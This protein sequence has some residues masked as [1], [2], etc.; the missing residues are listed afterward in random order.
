M[1]WLNQTYTILLPEEA[2]WRPSNIMKIPNTNLAE[3]L[4]IIKP[5]RAIMASAA[6]LC[7]YLAQAR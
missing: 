5:R 1:A 6:V 4:V 7:E 3:Q 2:F